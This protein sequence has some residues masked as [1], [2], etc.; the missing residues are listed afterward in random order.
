MKKIVTN[1]ENI[2][3]MATTF[4]CSIQTVY[5]ALAY[6]TNSAYAEKIRTYARKNGAKELVEVEN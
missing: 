6:R 1:S 4:R 5:N 3:K 2:T